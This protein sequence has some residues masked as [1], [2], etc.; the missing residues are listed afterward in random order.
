M[1]L[2]LSRG[3]GR[4][5]DF[6]T[7]AACLCLAMG[8]LLTA[9]PRVSVSIERRDK[10]VLFAPP[11]HN[12]PARATWPHFLHSKRE[13]ELCWDF[14]AHEIRVEVSQDLRKFQDIVE[15]VGTIIV[16]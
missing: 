15:L 14:L 4:P 12:F 9:I 10:M 2:M 3:L 8:V 11:T 16:M 1:L 13:R 6:V 5:Q 7:V